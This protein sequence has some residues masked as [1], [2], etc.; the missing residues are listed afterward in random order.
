MYVM[1]PR[2]MSTAPRWKLK[3]YQTQEL[4][5]KQST[6]SN[7]HT[8]WGIVARVSD[9]H[10]VLT[11]RRALAVYVTM[12]AENVPNLRAL[13]KTSARWEHQLAWELLFEWVI[14]MPF[15]MTTKNRNSCRRRAIAVNIVTHRCSGSETSAGSMTLPPLPSTGGTLYSAA[16]IQPYPYKTTD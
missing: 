5:S 4:E 10:M 3:P 9:V 11:C 16:W 8:V 13:L 7:R 14:I 15:I 1:N 6:C 12:M 2:D